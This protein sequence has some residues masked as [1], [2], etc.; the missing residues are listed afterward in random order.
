MVGG[1]YVIPSEISSSS[2]YELIAKRVRIGQSFIDS[3]GHDC[4]DMKQV[5]LASSVNLNILQ[6]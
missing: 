1:G 5:D 3:I 4:F 2:T 6:P